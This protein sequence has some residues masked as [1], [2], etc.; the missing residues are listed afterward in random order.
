ML[1]H[2]FP[3]LAQATRQFLI[4]DREGE[5]N[6]VDEVATSLFKA[7]ERG[8]EGSENENEDRPRKKKKTSKKKKKSA[9]SDKKDK[10][11]KKKKSSSSADSSRSSSDSSSSKDTSSSDDQ[12]L[13]LSAHTHTQGFA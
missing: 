2:V 3:F 1:S 9:K 4:W 6:T 5:E 11:K 8:L 12:A 10:K 7:A 13:L